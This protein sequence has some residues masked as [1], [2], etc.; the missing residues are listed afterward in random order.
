VW[1]ALGALAVDAEAIFPAVVGFNFFEAQVGG[2]AH[3]SA[4]NVG[5]AS[6]G[7]LRRHPFVIPHPEMTG[8]SEDSGGNGFQS[9]RNCRFAK[10]RFL[11]E[12]GAGGGSGVAGIDPDELFEVWEH[13][14]KGAAGTKIGEDVSE[15]DAELIECHVLENV[16][17]VDRLCR[18]RRD[19]KALDDVAV[20]DVFGVGRKSFFDQQRGEEWKAALQP[21]RWTSIEVLPC[22]WSTHATAKLHIPVIHGRIIHSV[23]DGFRAGESGDLR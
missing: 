17:A 19:G 8:A 9:S 10:P 5:E 6:F 16:G 11:H 2:I 12:A 4:A 13:E 7:E 3:L 23:G 20:F 18:S 21:K 1:V 15:G 14:T 22:F